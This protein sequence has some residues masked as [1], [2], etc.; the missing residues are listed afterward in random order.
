M[1]DI[2]VTSS[3]NCRPVGKRCALSLRIGEGDGDAFVETELMRLTANIVS[4]HI[5]HNAV[6][7]EQLPGLIREVHRALA[8]A[9]LATPAPTSIEPKPA[10]PELAA[11]QSVFGGRIVCLDCGE[12]FRVLKRHLLSDHQ[13]TPDQYRAKWGLPSSYPMVAPEYAAMRSKLAKESGLGRKI[14]APMMRM[15]G[16]PKKS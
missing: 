7:T 13:M 6:S 15:R 3:E 4:A 2:S 10:E 5:M 11:T 14:E 12:S 1:H 16:R 8:T 9:A